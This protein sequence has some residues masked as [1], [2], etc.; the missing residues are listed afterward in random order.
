MP[1]IVAKT[2][3]YQEIV[4]REL[5]RQY[6]H[7]D[8]RIET[9]LKILEDF[10]RELVDKALK[11]GITIGQWA[12]LNIEIEKL[13]TDLNKKLSA[14]SKAGLEGSWKLG[15]E[16][17][18]ITSG[19]EISK[20]N[21]L[22]VDK[23][24]VATDYTSHEVNT[25]VGKIGKDIQVTLLQG[26]LSELSPYE[27]VSKL[28][29]QLYD[30]A[31][32]KA[33]KM[34]ETQMMDAFSV[35]NRQSQLEVAD[36]IP[37]VLKYWIAKNDDR[38]RENHVIA[39]YQ[40]GL[41]GNPGPIP[42]DQDYRVGGENCF[43]PHDPSLSAGNRFNCRCVSV[44]WKEDWESEDWEPGQPTTITNESESVFGTNVVTSGDIEAIWVAL[45]EH[46]PGKH[47]QKTHGRRH[48]GNYT[49]IIGGTF[50][51]RKVVE[52]FLGK[53]PEHLVAKNLTVEFAPLDKN[54]LGLSH[55][56]VYPRLGAKPK[57]IHRI[58]LN[59]DIGRQLR[60]TKWP[61]PALGLKY[62]VAHEVGHTIANRTQWD[63]FSDKKFTTKDI[64]LIALKD[65]GI[66]GKFP[67]Y[68]KGNQVAEGWARAFGMRTAF[69][70]ST[71]QKYPEETE[72]LWAKIGL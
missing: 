72:Q 37:D 25:F 21:K 55:T 18:F 5:D 35:A 65:I 22:S 1:P 61:T 16:F 30:P 43:G 57:L 19:L 47:S 49:P 3:K 42:I 38:T 17:P 29:F 20:E 36:E 12:A 46:L 4:S 62:V 10:R 34:L 53:L 54:T 56:F 13:L 67:D 2:S 66:Y 31:A 32:E 14:H 52:N 33:T 26:I 44:L 51:Q 59:K 7:V 24:L 23:F 6:T 50:A 71:S 27:V 63:E 8:D 68:S 58:Y 39:S 9:A 69:G 28:Q 15:R 64:E 48:A 41:S 70:I 40:Y 45:N 60:Q 11:G